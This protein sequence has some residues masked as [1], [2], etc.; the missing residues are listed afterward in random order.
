MADT[1]NL[2]TGPIWIASVVIVL[3]LVLKLFLYATSRWYRQWY[4]PARTGGNG[5]KV[6]LP[7][8]VDVVYSFYGSQPTYDS[9]RGEIMKDLPSPLTYIWVY[10]VALCSCVYLI[11]GMNCSFTGN[12]ERYAWSYVVIVSV[13]FMLTM[14]R[15]LYDYATWRANA[16]GVK[17]KYA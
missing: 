2:V 5:E 16:S 12:C 1:V 11:Y 17:I 6:V 10:L 4:I 14:V 8:P 7:G 9:R 15:T 13:L 3:S